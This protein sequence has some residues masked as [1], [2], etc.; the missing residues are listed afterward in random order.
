MIVLAIQIF[1]LTG[2]YPLLRVEKCEKVRYKMW[3]KFQNRLEVLKWNENNRVDKL[4]GE[5]EIHELL[6]PF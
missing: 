5:N 4:R 2:S 3:S 1:G 6:F